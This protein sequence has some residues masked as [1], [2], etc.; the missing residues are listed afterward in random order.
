MK[1]NKENKIIKRYK[2]GESEDTENSSGGSSR[3]KIKESGK[4][5]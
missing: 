4:D 5:K 3:R 1:R 2:I